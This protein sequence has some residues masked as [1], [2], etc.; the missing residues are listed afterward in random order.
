[1][2]VYLATLFV[3]T[4]SAYLAGK[5]RSRVHSRFWLMIAFV[6]MILVAGLRSRS[7][8]TDT[9]TYVSYYARMTSLDTVLATGS[10]TLE[11]GFWFLNWLV[12]FVS[13]Q[14]MAL[15]F[16]IAVIVVGCY[17]RAILAYSSHIGISFFVFMTMGFYT[18]FFNGARQ[19][20]ACAICALAIGPLL[21]RNFCK[22][23]FFVLL[24]ALFHKTALVMVPVYFLLNRSNSL[25]TNLLYG[26]IGIAGALALQR[27]VEF[28]TQ[29][30]V[31]Y[32][33]YATAGEGGGYIMVAFS[34]LLTV[35]FFVYK[36]SVF[37]DRKVY[38][39]FLNL[40]FFGT[41]ISIIS[42]FFKLNPSG[43][44]RLTMYFNVSIIFLWPIV[45]KNI[46]KKSTR[47]FF[48][49]IFVSGYLIF[50]VLTTD[51]FSNLTPYVFNSL[52]LF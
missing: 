13:D 4:L 31:R 11:Y 39:I 5:S 3:V 18:F 40:L 21:D 19:G 38:D 8:G 52:V 6:T 16:A 34:F 15:F 36:N 47:I 51:R 33:H 45:Y 7:V 43:I 46:K 29:F 49:Y 24:A 27:L 10:A 23:L 22:Y 1:M 48:S 2:P 30:D 12:H 14:Y 28:G 35:F 44:I 41:L 26:L 20:I 9:G 17:Q 50:F 42:I 37:T 25:K 32:E